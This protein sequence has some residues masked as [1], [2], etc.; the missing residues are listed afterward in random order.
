MMARLS[1]RKSHRAEA[2]RRYIWIAYTESL[3]RVDAG[4]VEHD[5][6]RVVV[7]GVVDDRE[8]AVPDVSPSAMVM[9]LDDGV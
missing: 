8:V 9:E 6:L 5:D 4:V 1:F 7:L 2:R 3:T